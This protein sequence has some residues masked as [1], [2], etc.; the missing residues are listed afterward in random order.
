MNETRDTIIPYEEKLAAIRQMTLAD[1]TFFCAVCNHFP[2]IAQFLLRLLLDKPDLTVTK[3]Q[4]QADERSLTDRSAVLD[5]LA[6][7]A[8]GKVYDIEV[9]NSDRRA[10]P[11]RARFH[12]SALDADLLGKN[13]NF[14]QLPETYVVFITRGD[15]LKTGRMLCRVERVVM[16]TG[17]LF[18]DR[19]HIVYASMKYADETPLGRALGDFLRP[20]PKDMRCAELARAAEYLKASNKGVTE[21]CEIMEK[22]GDKLNR[23]M[24]YENVQRMLK[25]GFD[26]SAIMSALNLTEAEYAEFS[27][28]AAG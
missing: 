26:K 20:N 27:V 10:Q 8:A 14:A 1:D 22:L 11:E 9:E 23:K 2:E 17:E 5:V 21:M 4:T 12:S 19:E 15:P 18:G 16:E 25:L 6:V 3:V 24:K 13:K 28:P 7:D